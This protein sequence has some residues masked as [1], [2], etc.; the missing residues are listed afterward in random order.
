[1]L[2]C[3]LAAEH[4]HEHAAQVGGDEW[5]LRWWPGRRVLERLPV[6]GETDFDEAIRPSG[7]CCPA[8]HEGNHAYTT[9]P[10]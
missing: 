10:H 3:V 9:A 6:C 5:W 8:G 2:E 7:C 1:M 4:G